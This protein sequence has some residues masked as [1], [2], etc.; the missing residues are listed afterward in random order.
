MRG[1]KK[2]ATGTTTV[3]VLISFTLLITVLSFSA[4]LMVKHS[5]L[6]KA[7]RDYRLALD[8]LSN[9]IERLSA[10][11]QDELPAAVEKLAPS[12]FITAHLSGVQLRGE[13]AANDN[14][15]RVTLRLAWDEPQRLQAPVSLAAWISPPV[16]AASRERA[17]EGQP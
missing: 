12:E 3:E 1:F 8:E 2:I 7:Q 5:R 16:Q 17:A 10:L 13:L 14:A 15:R 9:Q 4:P 11:P 6:L